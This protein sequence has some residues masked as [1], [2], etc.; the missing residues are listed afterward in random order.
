MIGI[1]KGLFGSGSKV[2]YK[3]LMDEGAIIVDV[4]TTGEYASG[5]IK[6]SINIPLDKLK[7]K[8]QLLK[9]K[10]QIIITCCASGVRSAS[11]KNIL[12]SAGYS[13]V[14]NGGSWNGLQNKI[15]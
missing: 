7:S 3:Q 8:L 11:A 12:K 6:N 1:L 14:H 10:N 5:H 4:R 2:N 9:N 13:V 15:K